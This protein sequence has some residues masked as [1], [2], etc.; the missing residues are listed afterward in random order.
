MGGNNIKK[1]QRKKN[2]KARLNRYRGMI[3][4]IAWLKGDPVLF[5][6]HFGLPPLT[7]AQESF[8]YTLLEGT[9]ER[10]YRIKR[11]RG[12]KASSESGRCSV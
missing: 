8:L 4:E 12:Q 6:K 10:H 3:Q 2:R 1:R 7:R 5:I 11:T 9:H